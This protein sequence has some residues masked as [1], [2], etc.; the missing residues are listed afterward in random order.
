[1]K[2]TIFFI[3]GIFINSIIFLIIAYFSLP[4]SKPEFGNYFVIK[5]YIN[6]KNI[7]K[8]RLLIMSASD[9]IYGID[10]KTIDSQTTFSPINYSLF[11]GTGV[12]L[13]YRITKIILASKK[14]DFILLPLNF[15]FYFE[16][17]AQEDYTFQQNMLM[18]GDFQNNTTKYDWIY[19][20]EVLGKSPP[21][22][23]LTGLIKRIKYSLC[24]K[25][26]IIAKI[27]KIWNTP[28]NKTPFQ[29][30]VNSL[31]QYGNFDTHNGIKLNSNKQYSYLNKNPQISDYF[32]QQISRLIQYA[33][34][35][36]ITLIFTYPPT[37]KNAKF[38]LENPLH[39]QKIQKLKQQLK[40]YGI[41]LMG[42]PKRFQFPIEFFYD[43]E[44]HL[45][46]SGAKAY[47]QE[48][49]EVLKQSTTTP[50]TQTQP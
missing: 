11:F 16:Q 3:I 27:E 23:L 36:N 14:N 6:Q 17:T 18:W 41:T 12:A 5:D 45:N 30:S 7:H 4:L 24:D 8:H 13:E 40:Q 44:Y 2:Q 43:T 47:T 10:G 20:L 49:I 22:L 26:C 35:N 28:N 31:N 39:Y 21:S 46:S 33:K 9:G 29:V 25:T 19:F 50:T 32:I 42:D 48:L 34:D 15:S 37:I 1:M 38:D